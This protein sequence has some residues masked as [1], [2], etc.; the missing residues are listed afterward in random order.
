MTTKKMRRKKYEVFVGFPVREDR[1][2]VLTVFWQN[3]R[4]FERIVVPLRSP[5]GSIE[6]DG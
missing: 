1:E 3:I 5:K 4:S 6:P 2:P